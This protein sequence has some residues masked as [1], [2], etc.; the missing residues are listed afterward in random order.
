MH[1][2]YQA[3]CKRRDAVPSGFKC[4]VFSLSPGEPQSVSVFILTGLLDES[5][6]RPGPL[7]ALLEQ[8][9]PGSATWRH[10]KMYSERLLMHFRAGLNYWENGWVNLDCVS[11]RCLT[12]VPFF[13]I[14]P[15]KK[16]NGWNQTEWEFD[17]ILCLCDRLDL[18][19]LFLR[20]WL[21]NSQFLPFGFS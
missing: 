3:I 19:W 9:R 13:L 10:A 4:S 21:C 20:D 14:L 18:F 12:F 16:I 17:F 1:T 8:S 6:R 5:L 11:T 7:T 15:F 2:I